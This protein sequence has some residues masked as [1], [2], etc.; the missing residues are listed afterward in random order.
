[1]NDWEKVEYT[2]IFFH[3]SSF[4]V[5]SMLWFYNSNPLHAQY[6]IPQH[7]LQEE[8]F[9]ANEWT[10]V[11]MIERLNVWENVWGKHAWTEIFF[12]SWSFTVQ[13][14]LWF[15]NSNKLR[16]GYCIVEYTVMWVRFARMSER[17]NVRMWNACVKGKVTSILQI[18]L[19]F[20]KCAVIFNDN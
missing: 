16:A 14:M 8:T 9:T 19:C 15:Y 3:S 17:I 6:C 4:A 11:R 5:Q 1:M 18:E 12:H 13:S 2:D 7:I 20:A 10:N